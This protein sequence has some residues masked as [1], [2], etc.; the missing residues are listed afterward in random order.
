MTR[1]L[2]VA[3]FEMAAALDAYFAGLGEGGPVASLAAF[4][5]RGE[6]HP[7]LRRHLESMLASP[8]LGSEA[9]RRQLARR[10][11]LRDALLHALDAH[12]LDA[13]VFPHQ[14]RLVVPIGEEQVE[15]NGVLANGTGLPSV[16]FCAG[17]SAPT[18]TAP[19]GVPVGLELLGR[20][21][22][23][24]RLLAIAEGTSAT[25]ACGARRRA[26]RWR[27]EVT[28]HRECRYCLS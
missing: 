10:T 9:Y 16:A 6:Y 13:F 11:V 27:A 24:P 22:S 15:R 7:S 19:R 3:G 12:R 8:G 4:V 21:R 23:E 25:P 2:G 14:R 20:D 26:R 28:R 17:F 5:A 18:P 1:D